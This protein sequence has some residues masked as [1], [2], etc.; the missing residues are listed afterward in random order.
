MAK[1]PTEPRPEPEVWLS[2]EQTAE[3]LALPRTTV[4]RWAR[5]GDE[6]LPAY[7]TWGEGNSSP[8]QFRFKKSD[9]ESFRALT[10]AKEAT[11]SE[12]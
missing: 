7:Q 12:T 4:Y 11:M 5:D 1:R 2:L 10:A 9:V 3:V 8:V 6:R